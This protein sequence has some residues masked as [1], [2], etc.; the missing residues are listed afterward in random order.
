[1][2]QAAADKECDHWHDD[3]GFMVHHVA[4][5]LVLEQSLQAVQGETA[6]STGHADVLQ[7]TVACCGPHDLPPSTGSRSILR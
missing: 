2:M 1:M 7:L 4:F 6:Q 3:A 5:T